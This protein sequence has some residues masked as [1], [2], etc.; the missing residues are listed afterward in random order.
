[1]YDA[2]RLTNRKIQK[3]SYLKNTYVNFQK[4]VRV[5]GKTCTCFFLKHLEVLQMPNLGL[6][7]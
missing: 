6:A 2:Y 7:K 3:K 4:H 1:M 5:S